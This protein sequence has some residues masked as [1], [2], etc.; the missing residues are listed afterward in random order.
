MLLLAG[1]ASL[2][3][4][5]L[6]G[7]NCGTGSDTTPSPSALQTIPAPY[8]ALYQRAAAAYHV[9]WTVLAAIG[10]IESDHGRSHAPGVQSG[11]NAV[12]C[13]AGPMQFNLR[14]GP[15]STWQTYRVDGYG[16]GNTDPYDPADAIAS[17]GRYLH[18]LLAQS[19]GDISRA[20]YGYNHSSLYVTD[21]LARANAYSARPEQALTAPAN[22]GC[23]PGQQVGTPANL[24]EA[25][26]RET[27]R[28]YAMLPAW[29]MAGGR[30]AEPI[31]ARLLDNA[32]WILRTY[33][34]RVTAARET[35]H[36]T[37]GDGTALDLIPAEPVDQSAWDATA[38]AL[39]RDLGW[40]APCGASGVR[41]ACPLVPAIQFVGY[42]GYPG[43]GSPRTCRAP[44][45]AA[46]LHISWVSPC[47]GTSAPSPPCASVTAF[48]TANAVASDR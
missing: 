12:G 31:D 43:H 2:I 29:T 17:A 45:C 8:L 21:V 34:L 42:E 4:A 18:T 24:H 35:G 27:P 10:A 16:D 46:H 3:P 5:L 44:S 39:A 30:A 7:A 40:T 13:C 23:A 26:R 41:P 33:H 32:L 28:A 19:H 25:E 22:A 20:V 37:H 15:P 47:Y 38:R 6:T 36:N 9:P 14:D 11:V 48:A 1:A